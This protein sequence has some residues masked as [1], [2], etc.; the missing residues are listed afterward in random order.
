MLTMGVI[1]AVWQDWVAH[2]FRE[3]IRGWATGMAWGFSSL[4]GAVSALLAGWILKAYPGLSTFG[5]LYLTACALGVISMIV[6]LA[7]RDPAEQE[8]EEIVPSLHDMVAAALHSLRTANFRAVLI[9]R[10][11]AYAGF[12]VG[13]YI[14]MHYLSD[15]GGKVSESLLVSLGAAQTLG[16]AVTC[17]ALGRLGDR[18]GH[19]FGVLAGAIFQ[20]ACLLSVLLISGPVGCA[21]AMVFA[22]CVGGAL[23]ISCMNLM[24]ETCPHQIRSAHLAIG[25]IIVGIAAMVVPMLGSR[26]AGAY[27][28]QA[29]MAGSLAMS[30]LAAVWIAWKVRDPRHIRIAPVEAE[31]AIEATAP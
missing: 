15:A 20:V 24:I 19:R 4:A 13:P 7:V 18:I 21:L 10:C 11:L 9:G 25:N 30:I 26:L 2:L 23:T 3:G 8:A 14:T 28:I 27:G 17:I 31:E 5:W 12:C 16:S 22:G 29:L 1:I 6:F